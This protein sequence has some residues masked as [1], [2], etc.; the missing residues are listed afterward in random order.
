M[1]Y[2]V[3]IVH[4]CEKEFFRSQL[5]LTSRALPFDHFVKLYIEAYNVSLDN[6]CL[7]FESE[8]HYTWFLLRWSS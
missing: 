6:G 5:A 8:A 1:P 2:T 4:N 3:Q 7:I